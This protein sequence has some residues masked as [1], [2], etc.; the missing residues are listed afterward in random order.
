MWY[1]ADMRVD[2]FPV[3]MLAPPQREIWAVFDDP[4]YDTLVG[5]ACDLAAARRLIDTC[6]KEEVS[7]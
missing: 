5:K 3:L 4:A 7:L 1:N 2:Y 6:L